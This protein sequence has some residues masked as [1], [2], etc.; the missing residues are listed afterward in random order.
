MVSGL[1]GYDYVVVGPLIKVNNSILF[2]NSETNF[3]MDGNVTGIVGMGYTNQLNFLDLAHKA[4]QIS[5]NIFALELGSTPN[6]SSLYYN[7]IPS[8]ILSNTL[9]TKVFGNQ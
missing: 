4:G 8:S 9:Y 7:E 1:I 3:Q 2:V 5:T 6:T